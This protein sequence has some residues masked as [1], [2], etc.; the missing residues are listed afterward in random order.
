MA[1]NVTSFRL[2]SPVTGDMVH[3][4]AAKAINNATNSCYDL[5]TAL[6][7]QNTKVENLSTKL[8]SLTSTT[9]SSTSST[10]STSSTSSTT[11]S[12]F[13]G[14]GL[15]NNQTGNTSYS[16]Q[17]SDNGSMIIVD[18]ASPVII[19]LSSTLASPYFFF[20]FNLGAGLATLTPTSGTINGSASFALPQYCFSVVEFY[21]GNWYA[22]TTP[23]SPITFSVVAH[24][25]ITSYNAT[26]GVFT[27][28]EPAFTDISGIASVAQ[29]GTGTSSPGLVAGTN[30]SITGTWPNQT[31][32]ASSTGYSGTVTTAKLTSGG[33]NGSQ[34]FV[35]GI[36]T[37][38]TPAT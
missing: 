13:P 5:Q 30:I 16:P 34:T 29:G 15:V 2:P 26:T 11:T 32:N 27:A 22:S 38:S 28:A 10:T 17:T 25:F 6:A 8:A 3:P 24:E 18:D 21:S 14:L 20:I 9:S 33:T 37:A 23:V 1:N 7:A 4:S 35:N 12:S 36:L 31:I 19:P